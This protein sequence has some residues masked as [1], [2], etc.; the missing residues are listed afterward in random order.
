MTDGKLGEVVSKTLEGVP[1]C[2]KS[3]EHVREKF[4]CGGCEAITEPPAPSHPIPRGFAGP[5]LLAMV[6]VSKFLLH[7][8]LNRQSETYAREGI[9]LVPGLQRDH[10][11]YRAVYAQQANDRELI[12][13]AR[14]QEMAALSEEECCRQF[15]GVPSGAPSLSVLID[16]SEP[17]GAACIPAGVSP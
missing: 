13:R 12:E 3:I 8:P 9:E 4:L 2:W 7:Q 16:L 5:S 6:L 15:F 10:A 11:G 1:R 17:F 14:W